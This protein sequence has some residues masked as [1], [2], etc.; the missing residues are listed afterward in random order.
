MLN[1]FVSHDGDTPP[2]NKV[3]VAVPMNL[4]NHYRTLGQYDLTTIRLMGK[5]VLQWALR[6]FP[7]CGIDINEQLL[8]P[9]NL[10]PVGGS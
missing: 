10:T 5:E 3:E 9:K 8:K 1:A 2:H 4:T 6:D 7:S